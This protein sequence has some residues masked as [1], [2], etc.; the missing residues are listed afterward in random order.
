M[1]CF[2]ANG[3]MC[4]EKVIIIFIPQ[5]MVRSILHQL[6]DAPSGSHFVVTQ[7]LNKISSCFYWPGPSGADI[8]AE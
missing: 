6:H 8:S 7:T 1:G 4:Q 3:R 5:D 2:S